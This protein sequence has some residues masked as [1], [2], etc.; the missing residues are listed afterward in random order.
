[1]LIE[2]DDTDKR[3]V[4]NAKE[5]YR[6]ARSAGR[7]ITDLD[8]N[9]ITHF[10][11]SLCG[12]IIKE[13]ELK[14]NEF[15]VRVLDETGDR[16]LIWDA[17]DPFQIREA[18]TLFKDY[19]KRGWRAYAVDDSGKSRRRIHDFDLEKQEILF[20]EKSIQDISTNFAKSVNKE[21]KNP[22]LKSEAISSFMAAFKNN[23]L[24]PRTYPG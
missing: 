10:R 11:P 17:A 5:H 1:M 4:E 23:K 20:E 12:F 18:A 14:E 13:K 9:I 3:E 21:I 22:V 15:A 16:R 6:N 24:V 8:G 7:I 19:I 2:W